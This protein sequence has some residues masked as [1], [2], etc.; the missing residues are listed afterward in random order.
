MNKGV[1]A[2][3]GAVVLAGFGTVTLM[4]MSQSSKIID[5]NKAAIANLGVSEKNIDVLDQKIESGFTYSSAKKAIMWQEAL[6]SIKMDGAM[7]KAYFEGQQAI[8]DSIKLA[9]KIK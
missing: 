2:L 6:D 1:I 3:G 5:K 9:Q 7:K 4:N 8:R